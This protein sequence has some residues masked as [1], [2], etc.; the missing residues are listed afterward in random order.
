MSLKVRAPTQTGG[1]LPEQPWG[2]GQALRAGPMEPSVVFRA[3]VPLL[4]RALLTGLELLVSSTSSVLMEAGRYV[5]TPASALE[6]GRV[7]LS[8]RSP[9]AATGK[10]GSLSFKDLVVPK[11][12]NLSH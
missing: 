8:A 10:V 12:S 7:V 6:P 2:S 4:P 9:R 5:R 3:P 1:A 11:K